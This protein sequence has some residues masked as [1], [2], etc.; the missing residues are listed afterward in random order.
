VGLG[1][2]VGVGVGL[3]VG[4]GAGITVTGVLLPEL[5]SPPHAA[6]K[7][8]KPHMATPDNNFLIPTFPQRL[9]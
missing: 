7:V 6:V 1:V 9:Y 4:V 3:G 5:S 2:G 8:A